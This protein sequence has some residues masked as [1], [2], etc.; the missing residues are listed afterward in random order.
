MYQYKYCN[1][2][3]SEECGI[4]QKSFVYKAQFIIVLF[5][6]LLF[7]LFAIYVFHCMHNCGTLINSCPVLSVL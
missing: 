4:S 5:I 7:F 6:F 1:T 2:T 3:L